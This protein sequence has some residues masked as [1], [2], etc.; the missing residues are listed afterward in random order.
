M[1]V[2]FVKIKLLQQGNFPVDII[3]ISFVPF[4]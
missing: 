4:N 1:I 2:Q 3:S